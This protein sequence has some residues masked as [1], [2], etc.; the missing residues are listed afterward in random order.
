MYAVLYYD[1]EV[2]QFCN[3][4]MSTYQPIV[5]TRS[6]CFHKQTEAFVWMA[7]ND[8]I[9]FPAAHNLWPNSPSKCLHLELC[10]HWLDNPN[11]TNRCVIGNIPTHYVRYIIIFWRSSTR[12]LSISLL[13]HDISPVL[14]FSRFWR[15]KTLNADHY[16]GKLWFDLY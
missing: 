16:Q 7:A 13:Q 11:K 12:C 14:R 4:F 1:I 3:R 5:C 15:Q 10:V 9:K 6:T 8:K 2:F